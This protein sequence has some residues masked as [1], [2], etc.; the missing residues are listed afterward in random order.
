MT[1][2][3]IAMNRVHIKS[4]PDVKFGVKRSMLNNR[5]LVRVF[6]ISRMMQVNCQR[7]ESAEDKRL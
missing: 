3:N 7:V 4:E 1:E 2:L 5:V 6:V